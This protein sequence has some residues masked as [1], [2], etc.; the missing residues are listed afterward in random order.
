M[1][2]DD[3]KNEPERLRNK[4]T[5]LKKG[6]ATGIIMKVSDKGGLSIYGMGRFPPVTLYRE[7]WLRILDMS[8]D[9][10]TFIAANDGQLK[11]KG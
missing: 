9:I 11:T 4:N 5:A 10:R 7:Q 8:D 3:L 6:A 2:D 1:A